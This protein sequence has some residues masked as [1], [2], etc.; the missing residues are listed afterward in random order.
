M[1]A[2]LGGATVEELRQGVHGTVV[3]PGDADYD[4]ARAVWNAMIDRRPALVVRCAEVADVVAAVRFARSQDLEISVRGG[5]H[6]LPGFSTTDGGLVIDLSRMR[7][8]RVD[9]TERRALVEGGATWADVDQATQAA[10]LAVTGGL[11][12]TT[13]VGGFTLGGGIGWLTRRYGLA[14]DN[15]VGAEI[16]TA[17]GS[18][19]RASESENADLLW[20]LRGG[21]GNFGVVTSFEFR[22]FPLGPMILGGPVFYPGEQAVEVLRSWRDATDD[23]PDDLTTLISLGSAPPIP[24]IPESWHGRPVATLVGAFAGS[25][26]DG[27]APAAPLRKLGDPIADLLGEMPYLVLQTLVDPGWGPGAR[28]YF[29]SA[30]LT[31]LPDAAIDVLAAAHQSRPSPFNEIHLHHMGGAAARIG[32]DASAFGNRKA[33]FL[34]NIICRWLEPGDDAAELAWA[35]GLRDAMQPFATGGTYV[36]FLGLGDARVRDAYDA[37]RYARL[38][39]L[40]RRWDPTNAFHLNQNIAPGAGGG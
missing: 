14:S 27:Q 39:D 4:A 28:N 24:P 7:D 6:S 2:V 15:L 5:G 11:V 35:R 40:K 19:V 32:A 26:A 12:S 17:D 21:G 23:M 9:A 1:T 13:G 3:A 20:G 22:L 8:V 16:V 37:E 31:G 38:I 18:V 10:G 25:I 30:F 34:L 36:N 33:P 29:T